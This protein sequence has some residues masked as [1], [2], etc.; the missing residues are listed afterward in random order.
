MANYCSNFIEITGKAEDV[1][2]L[3]NA[4]KPMCN[5]DDCLHSENY[6]ELFGK[7]KDR[8]FPNNVPKGEE[9][10]FFNVYNEYGS[11]WFTPF[12]TASDI[13][14]EDDSGY[15]CISGDSAWSPVSALCQKLS[16][17]YDVSIS[18][19][20]EEPGC[21]F[22]GRHEFVSGEL[23]HKEE[24]TYII[25]RYLSDGLSVVLDDLE[26]SIDYTESFVEFFFENKNLFKIITKEERKELF[27]NYKN[28]KNGEE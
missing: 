24:T 16:E 28:F 20:F 22:G 3:L 13:D 7:A 2:D 5:S 8:Y 15:I 6:A 9:I 12:I 11:K 17:Y 21:D 14:K 25:W 10:D 27:E 26:C 1:E 18:I 4:L 23:T 19:E